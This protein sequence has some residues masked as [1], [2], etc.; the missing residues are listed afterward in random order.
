MPSD[1]LLIGDRYALKKLIAKGGMGEVWL[2][3]HLTLKSKVAIK[4]LHTAA[5]ASET[6]RRRFLTEARVAANLRTRHAVQVFDFGVTDDGRPYLVMELL[7]GDTLADRIARDGRLSC[8]ATASILQ[9]A[10]R[11]LDR[12]HQLGI[13]HRDFK[14]Q[15]V[16]LHR[17]HEE[18]AEVVK[19]VDFG[20]AKLLTSFDPSAVERLRTMPPPP[21]AAA[22]AR[23]DGAT[24]LT[25]AE[26]PPSTAPAALDLGSV[27]AGPTGAF[28][29]PFY[30]APEQIEDASRVTRAADI[31]AFG[32]VAYEC[33]TGSRPYGGA[34]VITM[35]SDILNGVPPNPAS[36]HEG[37]PK[38]FDAWFEIACARD[39]SRRFPSALVAANELAEA[40]GQRVIGGTTPSSVKIPI[41]S[42]ASFDGARSSGTMSAVIAPDPSADGEPPS[43]LEAAPS[44]PRDSKRDSAQSAGARPTDESDKAPE[45]LSPAKPSRE[46]ASMRIL[47]VAATLTLMAAALIAGRWST[48]RD[49]RATAASAPT[50]SSAP[51]ETAKAP[52]EPVIAAPPQVNT[53]PSQPSSEVQPP[54]PPAPSTAPRK[55]PATPGSSSPRSPRS[56]GTRHKNA[57]PF[58]MPPLGI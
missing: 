49:A 1:D 48:G 34:S 6:S 11:A 47:W 42:L 33:L 18:G 52:L 23:T 4:L 10:A 57:S 50:Q 15:N 43:S 8:P 12:A 24:T 26:G 29:T 5:T 40:L 41:P 9:R 19:V 39:P 25:S 17:D 14:P 28:G 38:S 54:T 56:P 27:T 37:V 35:L 2:A 21:P 55:E 36:D 20:I 30:M 16:I 46:V 22:V 51:N 3:E 44:K 32:V 13:V 45:A 7:E 58:D 53:A 31:W